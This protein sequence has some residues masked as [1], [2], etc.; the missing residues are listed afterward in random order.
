[1]GTVRFIAAAWLGIALWATRVVAGEADVVDVAVERLGPGLYRFDVSVTHADEG[2]DHYADRWEILDSEGAVVATR[3]LRH[4]H[5][6]EQPFT[7]SLPRVHI[8]PGLERVTI[9]AHDAVHGYGG[10]SILVE[11][12]SESTRSGGMD[13]GAK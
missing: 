12:P 7:R 4:P 1:M 6:E 2:W 13:P 5:V 3:V 9:R 8:A 11:L 10:R